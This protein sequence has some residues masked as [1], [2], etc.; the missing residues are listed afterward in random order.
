M[1][2]QIEAESDFNERLDHRFER[3]HPDYPHLTLEHLA[4]KRFARSAPMRKLNIPELVRTESALLKS[5]TYIE[6][7]IMDLDQP[8]PGASPTTC[9]SRAMPISCLMPSRT[10]V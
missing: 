1:K 7:K 3:P 10:M 6:E 4:V 9:M 2:A 5:L 8:V